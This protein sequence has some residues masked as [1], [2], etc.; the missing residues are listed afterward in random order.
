MNDLI[1]SIEREICQEILKDDKFKNKKIV[2]KQ[3]IHILQHNKDKKLLQKYIDMRIK[4]LNENDD[5]C[6]AVNDAIWE[7]DASSS[8]YVDG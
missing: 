5:I 1:D 7:K 3:L 8:D 6:C 2:G 4:A